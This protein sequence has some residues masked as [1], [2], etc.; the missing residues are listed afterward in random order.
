LAGFAV[1]GLAGGNIVESGTRALCH[2]YCANLAEA[3][4]VI[5]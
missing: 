2:S 5:L 1:I 4:E 3:L